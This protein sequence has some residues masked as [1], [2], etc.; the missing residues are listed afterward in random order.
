MQGPKPGKQA[1]SHTIVIRVPAHVAGKGRPCAKITATSPGTRQDASTT[2]GLRVRRLRL[3]AAVLC[4]LALVAPTAQALPGGTGQG[5]SAVL[6]TP[7]DGAVRRLDLYVPPRIPRRLPVPLLMVLH[8]LYLEPGTVEAASGLDRVADAEGV[9]VV[10]PQGLD[11]S[12]NAGTCCGTS[13][14]RGVDDVGFLVH[15]VDV[16]NAL[17]A[18]DRDRVYVAGFSNGGMMALRAACARPDVFAAA[19][20]VSATL[21]SGCLSR[22]PSSALLVNGLQD[23]TVPYAGERYSTFLRT[24]LNPVPT[25]ALTL[26][27]HAGC[28]TSRAEVRAR[29]TVQEFRGCAPGARVTGVVLPRMGHHWP[30]QEA[31]G[32]DGQALVWDFLSHQQRTG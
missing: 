11:R 28:V 32:V 9:A 7:Y 19:A 31:D 20:A 21:Q 10:Y 30:T 23:K 25:A 29:F 16:V 6:A 18:V 24:A 3:L 5:V 15:A 1:V 4:A 26:A 13:T 27:R 2:G 14:Q 17:Q 8:G 12:W 22:S